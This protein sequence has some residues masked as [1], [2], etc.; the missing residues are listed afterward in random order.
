MQDLNVEA[1]DSA[2]SAASK[3][4]TQLRFPALKWLL[5]NSDLQVESENTVFLAVWFWL[6]AHPDTP[7]D[8]SAQLLQCIRWKNLSAHIITDVLPYIIVR[9]DLRDSLKSVQMFHCYSEVRQRAL[10]EAKDAPLSLQRRAGFLDKPTRFVKVKVPKPRAL[11]ATEVFCNPWLVASYRIRASVTRDAAGSTLIGVYLRS[12][13]PMAAKLFVRCHF[14]IRLRSE[15]GLIVKK[16]F[17]GEHCFHR[18]DG[19]EDVI[20][21][22]TIRASEMA[23]IVHADG[24]IM[25]TVW[26]RLLDF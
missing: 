26:V 11:P 25:L 20:H 4:W 19:A 9:D 2:K 15:N 7:Q 17:D 22:E 6:A 1:F 14:T 18:L 21:C 24:S 12:A 13:F 23:P 10:R 16:V 5:S 3:K 8:I